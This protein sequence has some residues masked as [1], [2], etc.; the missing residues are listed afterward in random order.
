MKAPLFDVIVGNIKGATMLAS[1]SVITNNISKTELL[2]KIEARE[3]ETQTDFVGIKSSQASC[4]ETR[5][6]ISGVERSAAAVTRSQ[7]VEQAKPLKPLKVADIQNIY[8]STELAAAQK[9]DKSLTSLW[10]RCRDKTITIFRG[11][12][13]FFEAKR[14]LLLRKS[15]I[16]NDETAEIKS[17]LVLPKCVRKVVLNLSHSGNFAGHLAFQKSLDRVVSQFFWPGMGAE[18]KRFCK[19][20]DICQRTIPKGRVTKVPLGSMPLIDTPFSRVVIDLVGPIFPAS[21]RGHRWILT[22]VDTATRYPEAVALKHIDTI[23]VAEA[24]MGIFSRVGVPRELQSDQGT[25]FTSDLMKEVCRLVSISQLVGTPYNPK[26]QG[27]CERFN[28]T[29]KQM[30]KKMCVEKPSDWDRYL[31]ALLFAY[32]EVPQASLGFSPFELLYGRALRGPVQILKELWSKEEVDPETKT[33]YQYVLE[34]SQKLQDTCQLAHE[35]LAQASKKAMTYYNR[36]TKARYFKEGDRVLLLLP[37]NNNKLLL[38]WNGPFR[39]KER[40]NDMDYRVDLGHKTRMFHA[41]LLKLYVERE[42]NVL[43]PQVNGS[44]CDMVGSAVVELEKEEDGAASDLDL[45]S[46]PNSMQKETY[47][48]V[49]I[50]DNLTVGQRA[51]V[52]NLL[53]EF[54]DIFSDVPKLTNLVEHDIQLTSDVPIDRKSTRLN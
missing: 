18:V 47:R 27:L 54:S 2:R 23:T 29:L 50:G 5:K 24:L 40:V 1:P 17:Q 45:L 3:A 19:S 25:Q 51:E 36:K 38:T 42:T 35:N 22:V 43:Q 12:K 8:T 30:L 9:A 34:L 52:E 16:C 26:N 46:L 20:C 53:A 11:R 39:I 37:T 48:D 32:R 49:K 44:F 4:G 13:S 28:G 33:P 15:Q 41:N 10:N 31:P 7:S 21:G 14:G 6:F